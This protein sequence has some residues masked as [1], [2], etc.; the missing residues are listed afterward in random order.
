MHDDRQGGI[1]RTYTPDEIAR[2]LKV[3]TKTVLRWIEAEVLPAA[4]LGRQWR[5]SERD[6]KHFWRERLRG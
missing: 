4:K 1:G 2:H 3:S 6:L 5:I